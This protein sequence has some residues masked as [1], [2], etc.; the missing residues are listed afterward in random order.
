M[1]TGWRAPFRSP[2]LSSF[3]AVAQSLAGL[4]QELLSGS[5]QKAMEI[6]NVDPDRAVS[7]GGGD[8]LSVG[9]EPCP[10]DLGSMPG[11][12]AQQQARFGIPNSRRVVLAGG[13]DEPSIG[14]EG[15]IVD[16]GGVPA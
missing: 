2:W 5:V 7:A 4:D 1:A 12:C 11:Q 10:V 6:G 8:E 16:P 3:A 13:D 14:R 15:G 9:R